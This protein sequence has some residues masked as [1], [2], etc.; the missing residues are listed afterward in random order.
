MGCSNIQLIPNVYMYQNDSTASYYYAILFLEKILLQT[1]YEAFSYNSINGKLY[2]NN[3]LNAVLQ[4]MNPN[5]GEKVPPYAARLFNHWCNSRDFISFET[6]TREMNAVGFVNRLVAKYF[7]NETTENVNW[8]ILKC[9]F[10]KLTKYVD[11]KG[12]INFVTKYEDMSLQLNQ[13]EMTEKHDILDGNQNCELWCCAACGFKNDKLIVGSIM[14][15]YSRQR[16]CGMCGFNY[17][18]IPSVSNG[19]YGSYIYPKMMS[20]VVDEE[21]KV[22]SLSATEE[23]NKEQILLSTAVAHLSTKGMINLLRTE[24]FAKI[25][26]KQPKLQTIA[27]ENKIVKYFQNQN[28]NGEA[29][30]SMGLKTFENEVMN[31]YNGKIN[32]TKLDYKQIYIL[33]EHNAVLRAPEEKNFEAAFQ[34]VSQTRN[35]LISK[36]CDV[37]CNPNEEKTFLNELNCNEKQRNEICDLILHHYID[38]HQLNHD[39]FVKILKK[40]VIDLYPDFDVDKFAAKAKECHLSGD[41]FLKEKSQYIKNSKH[42]AKTFQT[43]GYPKKKLMK[44]YVALNKWQPRKIE[45]TH[46]QFMYQAL[47]LYAENKWQQLMTKAVAF[48][49]PLLPKIIINDSEDEIKDDNA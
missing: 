5:K 42:F 10:P 27:F 31:F 47:F 13:K 44:I 43:T 39:N 37:Y 9:L 1:K 38:K 30:L 14:I 32:S 24:I 48:N 12:Q 19:S 33:V 6:L 7:Y 34:Q 35:E 8:N 45:R 22:N 28:I 18:Y 29:L 49:C 41:I 16:Q 26:Q 23:W 25:L 21:K 36:L 4:L 17:Q 2:D 20:T 46:I 15:Y 11:L 3:T 40:T